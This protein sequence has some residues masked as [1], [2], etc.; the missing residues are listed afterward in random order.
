MMDFTSDNV[1][2][3]VNQGATLSNVFTGPQ[4]TLYLYAKY[5]KPKLVTCTWPFGIKG[6][7][8]VIK[9]V[10]VTKDIW[11][12]PALFKLNDILLEAARQ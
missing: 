5:S 4:G 3:E 2:F 9:S 7:C 11:R 6:K 8:L 10:E 12:S 1:D